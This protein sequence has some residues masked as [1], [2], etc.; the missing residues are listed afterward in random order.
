MQEC[1]DNIQNGSLGTQ[2]LYVL[3]LLALVAELD[4][5]GRVSPDL[6]AG[7]LSGAERFGDNHVFVDAAVCNR[8]KLR[9]YTLH[10]SPTQNLRIFRSTTNLLKVT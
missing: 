7:H 1:T 2:I 3:A 9:I 8:N 5:A 6:P 4:A 10:V